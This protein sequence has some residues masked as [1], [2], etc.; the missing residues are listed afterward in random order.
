MRNLSSIRPRH[1]H[2]L[3]LRLAAVAALA[4]LTPA[5]HAQQ[6][7]SD[8]SYPDALGCANQP[9][10]LTQ[11]NHLTSTANVQEHPQNQTP[12]ADQSNEASANGS[13][14][15]GASYSEGATSK[16]KQGAETRT[17]PPEA[18][19]EFQYFVA[20]TTGKMLPI[21]G[22]RLF[23]NL[24]AAF[25]PID[26]G[27]APG[28]LV[29]GPD[30]ELRIRIWGQVNF[31]A[32]LRV[33][34]EGEIYLPKIGAVH[35][36]GLPFSAIPAHLRSVMERVYR[37]FELSVDLGDIHTIQ[38]YVAG[39]AH[40]PGEYT[41]SAL[42]SL[43]DAMFAVG[44][45]SASGS[46]RHVQLK[47]QG[48]VIAD[49]DLYALLVNGDKS[50]DVQL[51]PGDVLYI[52][53]TGPQVAVLGSVRQAGIYEL[54][55]EEPI[56]QILSTAGG[57]TAIASG[58]RMFIDRIEDRERRRAIEVSSDATG[59]A[60]LLA[61]GDI[62]R[63]DPIVSIYHDTVTLRGAV[64][65]PGHFLWHEGMRLSELIPERD[66][67]LKRDYWWQRTQ[68]GLPTPQLSLPTSQ[69][70]QLPLQPGQPTPQ[71]GS[72]ASQFAAPAAQEDT[73]DKLAALK[74]PS[75]QTNWNQAVI[76]RLDTSTMSTRLIP[77][78]LG[79]LVLDHDMSQDLE[80]KPGDVVTIYAQ[81]SIQPPIGEQT[82]YV[83]L[84]G[85]FTHP[86]IYSVSAGET[87]RSVVERAGGL[88]D[89]AYLYASVF[90][91]V[92]TQTA[93]Q[94]Q[95]DEYADR[96]EHQ[97]Q[98]NSLGAEDS[99]DAS[100]QQPG[101][102]G[103][104][105]SLNREMVERVRQLRSTGRVVLNLRPQSSGMNALPEMHLEDGDKL[106]VPFVPET[107]QV[108]GAVFNPHAFLSKDTAR[109]GEYLH[110]AGGPN[111]DAD[112]RRMFVLRAD[113]S[114]VA[115]DTG[116]SAFESNFKS[117]RLYPG[118]AIVVPEKVIRPS[119]WNQLMIWSQLMS[120]LS[121]STLAVSA[122]R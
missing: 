36:A 107:I 119:N 28:D 98:R 121:I 109:V 71:P 111:R 97:M 120:Q 39:M 32:N 24:P 76:E 15:S 6:Q 87:L 8:G 20:A 56:A 101:S 55:G 67:L 37:N 40:Q 118:D 52:P 33:S 31:S 70:G 110:M 85:E 23:R 83:E 74:S 47:R 14:P 78:Q 49:F 1:E 66:A 68:L 35:V 26:H 108:V 42:S 22:A 48:K 61:D 30:D 25:G 113:G 105:A 77:F 19:N 79:K 21:Y 92:S 3:F 63:V 116:Y 102:G 4:V 34:R 17:V 99:A 41:V 60:T 95:L 16:R 89:R 50:G 51:Q 57:T 115:H 82:V 114:V 93:E 18:P 94:R 10:D 104:I 12:N 86:G 117:L 96:L 84:A 58:A 90:T 91:R 59:Q 69:L 45:P 9:A 65:N 53:A 46:M 64:A 122:A 81:Q 27:P 43:V 54:R 29:I 7:C 106:V 2:H 73:P 5:V 100:G 44:G 13:L 112:S 80:L 11:T 38:I 75:A 62:L 72:P 88:T 103:Q